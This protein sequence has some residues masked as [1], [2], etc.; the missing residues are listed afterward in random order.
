MASRVCLGDE[1]WRRRQRQVSCGEQVLVARGGL[2]PETGKRGVWEYAPGA[3]GCRPCRGEVRRWIIKSKA[4]SSEFCEIFGW[5]QDG[6]RQC[7]RHRCID[8]PLV[9]WL[10][11]Q[12]FGWLWQNRKAEKVFCRY[13]SLPSQLASSVAGLPPLLPTHQSLPTLDL[14][15]R[16]SGAISSSNYMKKPNKIFRVRDAASNNQ[17]RLSNPSEHLRPRDSTATDQS[18]C[19]HA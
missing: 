13:C 2:G 17:D 14:G 16:N 4:P 7:A 8:G 5:L 19:Q 3:R 15:R 9:V 1:R 11:E 6:F 12:R 18:H 10:G